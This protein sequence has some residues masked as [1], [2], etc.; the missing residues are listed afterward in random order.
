MAADAAAQA[1]RRAA[2][3]GRHADAPADFVRVWKDKEGVVYFDVIATGGGEGGK[4]SAKPLGVLWVASPFH[5]LEKDAKNKADAI[6]MVSA[7]VLFHEETLDMDLP[8]I[9][10][11]ERASVDKGKRRK[12]PRQIADFVIG[13]RGPRPS[14]KYPTLGVKL[15]AKDGRVI[16]KGLSAGKKTPARVAGVA[17]KDVVVAVDGTPIKSVFDLR[18]ALGKKLR[19]DSLELTVRRGAKILKL[20][21]K[22]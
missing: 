15:L 5:F 20:Q 2:L 10:P 6:G 9:D 3:P 4:P 11:R 18:W 14:D 13:V 22:L 19:G 7:D 8:L 12:L 21:L 1:A 16:V 17:K